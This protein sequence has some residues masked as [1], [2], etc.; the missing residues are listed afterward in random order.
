MGKTQ[1]A[2]EFVHRYGQFFSGGVFWLSF[3]N[4]D[5]IPSEIAMCGGVGAMELRPDFDT[6][7]LAEQVKL[8][9]AA[10]QQPT[11][12]LL[13]FDNCEDPDLLARIVEATSGNTGIA[14]S[15]VGRAMGNT[16]PIG[17]VYTDGE[18]FVVF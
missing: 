2:S 10:W 9:Q 3:E 11:L 5:A 16:D 7:S 15:A 1:L 6:R 4:P 17:C 8:V 12:R 13:V 14:V 18:C